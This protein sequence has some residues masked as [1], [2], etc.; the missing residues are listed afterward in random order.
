MDLPNGT[1]SLEEVA[2]E[3]DKRICGGSSHTL[4]IVRQFSLRTPRS[5]LHVRARPKAEGARPKAEELKQVIE[6]H[7]G[8]ADPHVA[9]TVSNV[10]LW[11]VRPHCCMRL[12]CCSFGLQH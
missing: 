6:W 7:I 10:D 11:Q 9:W 1:T 2:E 5:D 4:G 3:P 12:H 8:F